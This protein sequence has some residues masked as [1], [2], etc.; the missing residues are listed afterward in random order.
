MIFVLF[1]FVFLYRKNQTDM[2]KEKAY[3]LVEKFRKLEDEKKELEERLE[4]ALFIVFDEEA[5]KCPNK[6]KTI[7]GGAKMFVVNM[8]SLLGGTWTTEGCVWT[9]SAEVLKEVVRRSGVIN[10]IEK[11]KDILSK[12]KNGI[13]KVEFKGDTRVLK[14]IDERYLSKVVERL[15]NPS[16]N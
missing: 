4:K 12:A 6:Y 2:E 11:M 5:A 15:Q 10:S 8:S 1:Y 3:E 16:K 14:T 13:C 9:E 7:G